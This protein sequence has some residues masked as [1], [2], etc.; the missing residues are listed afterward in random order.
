ME[1][2]MARIPLNHEGGPD[3]T[4]VMESYRQRMGF[5]PN[6]VLI[7]Q[8]RPKIVHA[9][10]QLGLALWDP[11]GTVD[12]G[13]KRLIG[14]VASRARGCQYCMAHTAGLSL[15]AGVDSAKLDAIWDYQSSPLYTEAERVAL[16]F[17]LAAGAV[18]NDVDDA[19]F[20]RMQAHWSDDDIVEIT[21]V[22]AFY[23]FLNCWN[24][25]FAT[26]LE[27]EPSAVGAAHLS[28]HGWSK[29]KHV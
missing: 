17:A 11:E 12:K 22:I 7:M 28:S 19:L 24:D 18:P 3:L 1:M 15:H 6:S 16:D 5:M 2:L 26:P 21:G 9:I 14:H 27:E 29:G 13:F 25:T 8:R 10:S 20:A 23:A 4:A